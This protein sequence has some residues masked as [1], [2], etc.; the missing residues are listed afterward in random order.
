VIY[1]LGINDFLHRGVHC[2]EEKPKYFKALQAE[3]M[4]VFPN[5]ELCFVLPFKGMV[6]NDITDMVHKDLNQLLKENAPKFRRYNPPSLR[7]KVDSRGIHPNAAG[8]KVLTDFYSRQFVTK[9]PSVFQ[10]GAGRV[11]PGVT[12]AAA[13]HPESFRVNTPT[14]QPLATGNQTQHVSSVP[15][16]LAREIAEAFKQMMQSQAWGHQPYHTPN[17]FQAPWPPPR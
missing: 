12:Y 17:M 2:F 14:P 9:R 5:A 15:G 11:I 10:Q 8:Q 13:H 4:R 16:G 6:G 7:G 3:S 1:S